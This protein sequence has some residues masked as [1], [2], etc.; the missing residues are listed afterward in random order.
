MDDKFTAEQKTQ[1][2]LESLKVDTNTAE[3]CQKHNIHPKTLDAWRKIFM[4]GG[5]AGL[6]Y[7]EDDKHISTKNENA[8]LR[9]IAVEKAMAIG[10]LKKTLEENSTK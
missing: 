5:R 9:R 3:L 2:I 10:I 1:I 7:D 8:L 6:N 4:D